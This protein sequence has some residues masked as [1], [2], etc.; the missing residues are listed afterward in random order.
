M[1][2]QSGVLQSYT[3]PAG[4]ELENQNCHVYAGLDGKVYISPYS[5]GLYEVRNNGLKRLTVPEYSTIGHVDQF[6]NKGILLGANS[7]LWF[8]STQ[9][10][11]ACIDSSYIMDITKADNGYYVVAQTKYMESQLYFLD[12]SFNKIS[13]RIVKGLSTFYP[14]RDTLFI[15]IQNKEAVDIYSLKNKHFNHISKIQLNAQNAFVQQVYRS[16]SFC[17]IKQL[18]DKTTHYLFFTGGK[19]CQTFK[20]GLLLSNGRTTYLSQKDKNISELKSF[21]NQKAYNLL[22]SEIK[23]RCS[24]LENPAYNSF[25]IPSGKSVSRY[26]TYLQVHPK[27]FQQSHSHS[28]F[29]LIE[30]SSGDILAASYERGLTAIRNH[31]YTSFPAHNL[32]YSNG[33][34]RLGNHVLFIHE[35]ASK[36]FLLCMD[37]NRRFRSIQIPNFAY[38]FFGFTSSKGEVYL[39]SSGQG[40]WKTDSTAFLHGV[41][42]WKKIDSDQSKKLT[43][44]LTIT[45]DTLGRIWFAH[46]KTG[47]GIYDAKTGT[48]QYLLKNSGE[49]AFGAM[50]SLRDSRGTL[51]FGTQPGGI[52]YYN[53]YQPST[54]SSDIRWLDHPL[55]DKVPRVTALTIHRNHLII[56]AY[57]KILALNLDSFYSGKINLKYLSA[58]ESNLSSYTEQNTMLTAKDG[59]IWYATHDNLYR[60]DFDAWL[61][62]PKNRICLYTTLTTSK[63]C[64][65][66]ISHRGPHL[67]PMQNNFT[68][69]LDYYTP[70]LLPRY[71]RTSLQFESD[72]LTWSKTS[73]N[74]EFVFTNLSPGAYKFHV[75][76]M[77]FDGTLTELVYQ[78]TINEFWYKQWWLW[79]LIS[80]VLLV[81]ILFIFWQHT[82][83]KLALSALQLTKANQSAEIDRIQNLKS[84]EMSRLKLQSIANK[85]RPH[86]ILNAL[87]TIG[88]ALPAKSR[89]EILLTRLS[90]SLN[91]LFEQSKNEK[92]THLLQQEWE[93][94]LI[95]IEMNRHMYLT[96]LQLEVHL[97]LDSSHQFVVPIG[98]LQVPVENALL[99]GLRNKLEHPHQ[100]VLNHHFTESELHI[101]IIDNGIGLNASR[102]QSNARKHGSGLKS[103]LDTLEIYNSV[104]E[105]QLRFT[106]NEIEDGGTL[107][108]IVIPLNFT[109][110]I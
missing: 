53:S 84:R 8:V 22:A 2:C 38:F 30:S 44:I 24:I 28:I 42:E 13:L 73:T 18:P 85:I 1:H 86:F 16:D 47:F 52:V 67:A 89:A 59:S 19:H 88:A 12:S 105:K 61:K 108:E 94:C 56:A 31:Q 106:L 97:P 83:K 33:A 48:T 71:L 72:S 6:P 60:W 9:G 49:I 27:L 68:I 76:I 14:T 55:F 78:I 43:N 96:D 95:T 10:G 15:G 17:I 62:L 65:T 40:L 102:K 26:F 45:E 36:R 98:L 63:Q 87:N 91:H 51:W 80:S 21:H 57:D 64:D 92:N 69:R 39:G 3:Y 34:F 104:N 32:I 75:Q 107:V 93:Q 66:L 25:F 50:A 23:S 58:H 20:G 4:E 90:K 46:P 7:G 103:I 5:N 11:M 54:R 35:D 79:L 101:A 110:E 109:Y 100:L 81:T 37:A 77:E 41:A 29:S 70:D 99:H 82:Q 74:T